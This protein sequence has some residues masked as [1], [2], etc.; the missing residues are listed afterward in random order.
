MW[1]GPVKGCRSRGIFSPPFHA[2]QCRFLPFVLKTLFGE[3]STT[4]FGRRPL[5]GS[6]FLARMRDQ[7]TGKVSTLLPHTFLDGFRSGSSFRERP[8]PSQMQIEIGN[9]MMTY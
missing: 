5:P 2:R 6:V 7:R 8:E 3:G 9:L 1:D 4:P